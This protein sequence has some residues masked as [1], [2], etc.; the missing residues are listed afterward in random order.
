MGSLCN[1]SGLRCHVSHCAAHSERLAAERLSAQI[2]P[3]ANKKARRAPRFMRCSG[4]PA[5]LSSAGGAPARSLLGAVTSG[6]GSLAALVQLKWASREK[7]ARICAKRVK[8]LFTHT[9]SITA[10]GWRASDCAF[11]PAIIGSLCALGFRQSY[12][13]ATLVSVADAP[14]NCALKTNVPGVRSRY[15]RR[16]RRSSR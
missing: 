9:R 13:L 12:R 1:V 6:V 8:C 14:E 15:N 5:G 4:P 7:C 10:G 3:G 16:R 11:V 2:M